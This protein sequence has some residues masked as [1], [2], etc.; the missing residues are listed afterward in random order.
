MLLDLRAKR[1]DKW[2]HNQ[3]AASWNSSLFIRSSLPFDSTVLR[4]SF[5]AR[6]IAHLMQ[7]T[8]SWDFCLRVWL[9]GVKSRNQIQ[10]K[11]QV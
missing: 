3:N 9:S 11:V 6:S 5:N 10:R 8:I 1:L 2:M 4:A 7:L